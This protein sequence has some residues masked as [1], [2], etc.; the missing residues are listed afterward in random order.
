MRNDNW[1]FLTPSYHYLTG[2]PDRRYHCTVKGDLILIKQTT[3]QNHRS[4]GK[5]SSLWSQD[6]LYYS[7]HTL[8]SSKDKENTKAEKHS[9]YIGTFVNL[10]KMKLSPFLVLWIAFCTDLRTSRGGFEKD[11]PFRTECPKSFNHSTLSICRSPD[12]IGP[13]NINS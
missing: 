3:K 8:R 13:I 2:L 9:I 4:R 12:T 5:C 10:K 7:H 1:G 6:I 11:I